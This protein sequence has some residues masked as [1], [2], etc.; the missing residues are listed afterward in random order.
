[1]LEWKKQSKQL[2]SVERV[3]MLGIYDCFGYGAGYNVPFEE[4]YRLI[5]K[6]GFDCVM[7]WW[8]DKFGRGDGYKEDARLA[9]K[10]DL[11]VNNIHAPVH[12]QNHL[13]SD[14]L[15]GENLFHTYMQCVKDCFEYDIPTMVIHLPDDK[16]PINDLGI[17]RLEY[18]VME[19]EKK[20]IQIAFENLNNLSNLSFVMG[21]FISENVGYCYDSCHHI[22]CAP[23]ADLLNIYGNRL[24]ALHL[25][26][27]GGKHNQH[28][29]PFDGN[30]DWRDVMGKIARSGYRGAT[31]LEPMNWDYEHLSIQQFLELAYQRAKEIEGLRNISVISRN[32]SVIHD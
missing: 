21:A 19:A 6:A 14:S 25:Q 1:M 31:M 20:N 8:S 26:D 3:D 4:R 5:K 30:I 22:N 32:K 9:R 17:K 18:I 28:Q 13:S 24:M 7:L 2:E 27:N 16:Y 15:D 23:N 11:L 10:A 12:E 29:L